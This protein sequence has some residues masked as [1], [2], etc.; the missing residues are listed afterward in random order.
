ML[1]TLVALVL[2]ANLFFFGWAQGWF[3]PGLPPPR[4][5]EHEPERI[6]AQL[7]ADAVTVLP[8][9]VASAAL[10]AARAAA[11]QCLQAGPF[12]E[13]DLP[14]AESMLL[15]A[16]VPAAAWTREPAPPPPRW[17]VYAGRVVDANA[18]R[19]REAELQRLSLPYELL[20]APPELAP[21][22]VLSRHD[23]QAAAEAAMAAVAA[24]SA[25]RGLRVTSLPAAPAQT[26]LRLA[27][28][29]PD[30]QARLQ[31]LSPGSLA[32]EF[33]PCPVA[34]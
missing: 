13:A 12:A 25:L 34:P 20:Q 26:F 8:A 11:V 18:R 5:N 6:T 1:R 33:R 17:L 31:A 19:V 2:L 9:P 30:Q 29:D 32:S 15:A 14:A 28:A 23:S 4:Q 16:R 22:L 7:H 21:G 24:S 27:R 3:A 10:N